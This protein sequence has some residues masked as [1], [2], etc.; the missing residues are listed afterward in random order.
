MNLEAAQS[1][2]F[3]PRWAIAAYV[4]GEL[5]PRE[6]IELE[7][8][9]AVCPDCAAELNGQKKLLHA[10]DS[11]LEED[12]ELPADFTKTV[13]TRAESSVQGLRCPKERSRALFICALLF[14]L[15]IL[16][17]GS[18]T[19]AVLAVFVTFFEQIW[20]VGGFV[21][22]LVY[23]IAFGIT[24]ILR[25]LGHQ[26][27]YSSALALITLLGFLAMILFTLSRFVQ[28]VKI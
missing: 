22:H 25:S 1:E 28:R 7:Q 27:V 20:A 5:T 14:L 4:D 6:E 9:F 3:C 16:G 15:A 19:E 24:V 13:V 26:F 23:D 21:A 12:F 10:L 2:N 8:H 18:E 17:L 11:A